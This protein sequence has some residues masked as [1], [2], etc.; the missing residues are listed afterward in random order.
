MFRLTNTLHVLN[1]LKGLVY[2]TFFFLIPRG[3][4]RL[5]D[6]IISASSN[7]SIEWE[8]IS[9]VT[10]RYYFSSPGPVSAVA[11]GTPIF[12]GIGPRVYTCMLCMGTYL[13]RQDIPCQHRPDAPPCQT[14]KAWSWVTR[15]LANQPSARQNTALTWDSNT[16]EPPL[17]SELASTSP[18]PSITGEI[19]DGTVNPK[20]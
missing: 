1:F 2:I 12:Y 5:I 7:S 8:L 10:E 15:R 4:F 3:Y 16:T 20:S 6:L 18:M 11:I 9:A 19:A 17:I 14:P 13:T